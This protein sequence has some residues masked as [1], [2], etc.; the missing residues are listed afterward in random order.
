MMQMMMQ[1]SLQWLLYFT[2][3]VPGPK[4]RA[5]QQQV[6]VYDDVQKTPEKKSHVVQTTPHKH[7][8]QSH[9]LFQIKLEDPLAWM[10]AGI[11]T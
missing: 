4:Q 5:A 3:A 10:D 2:P 11:N 6:V 9:K 1:Q 7:M 8:E